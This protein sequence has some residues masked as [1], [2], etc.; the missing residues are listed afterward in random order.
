MK[1]ADA[2]R[3]AILIVTDTQRW[4]MLSCYRETGLRTPNLD[5]L[6]AGGIRFERAYTCQPVCGPARAA[7][8]TGTWPHTN[9][10][11]GNNMP[12]G[13]DTLTLGQR[14]RN[15]GLR[16]GYIGKWHLD[17][18]GYFGLGRCPDGWDAA[19][20]YDMRMYLDELSPR[21]RLRSR[22][23]ETILDDLPDSF[24]FGHRCTERALDFLAAHAREDFLLVLSYDEPHGPFLCPKRFRDA[25]A[26]FVFP[27]GPN[28]ADTLADKPEHLRVWSRQ[29]FVD[30]RGGAGVVRPEYFGCNAFVDHEIGRVLDA[31]D[32]FAPGA[33]VIHTSDHGDML[34]SHRIHNKG[35]AVFDEIARVPLLV[36][37]PG[38]APATVC[39]HPASHIDLT[40]T[41][42]DYFGLPAPPRLEGRSML[43]TFRDPARRANDA[44]FMEFG[45]YEVDHDAFGGYQPIRCVCDGRYKLAVNLLTSDELYDLRDDPHELRN[46]IGSSDHAAVR[47]SLHDRLLAWM[48]DTRD[49]FRGYYWERRPWRADARPAT[50]QY[51]AKTRPRPGEEGVPPELDY[52]TGL[53][54]TEETA[55]DA[56]R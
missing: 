7:M 1:T 26:D 34:R 9:G 20:W 3:Q 36:R 52:N 16:A 29:P 28:V 4:D 30:D 51:T 33:L 46:L 5:R 39:P 45:R 31:I 35:P 44:V 40:P 32:R 24:T 18:G 12:L 54:F 37:W 41:L 19:C 38:E 2:R 11:L 42:L 8:F 10:S 48:N 53:E 13:A 50:W 17:A 23:A 47:D 6:A 21:E 56:R 55:T 49:P 27:T 14:L 43:P 15:A 22:R 25:Y